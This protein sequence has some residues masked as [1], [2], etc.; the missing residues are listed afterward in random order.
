MYQGK[1]LSLRLLRGLKCFESNVYRVA[2]L[3]MVDRAFTL[4]LRL[5][6][7]MVP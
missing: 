4:P 3:L 2:P 7:S 5:V 1:S 6:T